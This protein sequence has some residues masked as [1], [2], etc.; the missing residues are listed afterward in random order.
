MRRYLLATLFLLSSCKNVQTPGGH[1]PAGYLAQAKAASGTFAGSFQGVPTTLVIHFEGD[2]P[3][4]EVRNQ[5]NNDL[6][7]RGCGSSVGILDSV[8]LD[9]TSNGQYVLNTAYFSFS[10]NHCYVEGRNLELAF[11]RDRAAINASILQRTEFDPGCLVVAASAP[12][13]RDPGD[14]PDHCHHQPP[15]RDYL[16]G[17]FSRN[18]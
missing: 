7:G 9:E 15:T 10:S 2:R 12:V 14:I 8:D 17:R 11:S 16:T 1:V 3:V 13:A 4:V 6:L 18:P 5:Q